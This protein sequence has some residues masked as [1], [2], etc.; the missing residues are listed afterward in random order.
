MVSDMNE[1]RLRLLESV[2][3][4]TPDAVMIT[5]SEPI[6]EPGP[7]IIYVNKAFTK[8]TGYS[9]H[10][11]LGRSPRFLQSKKTNRETLDRL[12]QALISRESFSAELINQKKDQ[13]EFWVSITIAPVKDDAGNCTH[14]VS[15]QRDITEQKKADSMLPQMAILTFDESN[16]SG[17]L[18]NFPNDITDKKIALEALQ[19]SEA[20]FRRVIETNLI[21]V[22]IGKLNGPISFSNDAFLDIIGYKREDL[23][24]GTIRWDSITPAEYMAIEKDVTVSVETNGSCKPFKKEYVRKDGLR[25]PA[26]VSLAKLDDK[27]DDCV[28]CVVDL[29]ELKRVEEQL[30]QSEI[31]Y[32]NALTSARIGTWS[33]DLH[34]DVI[35]WSPQTESLFGFD[36]GQF[37]GTVDEF[38]SC[39]HPDDKDEFNR[40]LK[41]AMES[42]ERFNYEF[43]VLWKDGSHHWLVATGEC[44][45]SEF[46]LPLQITGTVAEITLRK[47][48]EEALQ[49]LTRQLIQAQE[50]ERIRLARA[51]HDELGQALTAIKINLQTVKLPDE[52]MGSI[53]KMV[54]DSIQQIRDLSFD[55]RP[56]LLDDLGLVS[57]LRWYLER[58]GKKSGF[59]PYFISNIQRIRLPFDIET[60]CYRIVQEALTNI[61]R[62]SQAQNVYI[63]LISVSAKLEVFIKDDGVGFDMEKLKSGNAVNLGIAGMFERTQLVG[64]KIEIESSIG[65]GTEIRINFNLFPSKQEVTK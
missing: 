61:Q 42:R 40:V 29:T 23:E 1:E 28:G 33:W 50:N 39:I 37:R 32:Q 44:I 34:N 52:K 43:R 48:A 6:D 5:E 36:P 46:S 3:T 14:F 59:T 7:R 31:R 16:Q 64:G 17:G 8:M 56:S 54:D 38:Q 20:R 2:I 47:Q 25:V 26:L 18:Y 58:Q 53:L 15:I 21:G 9:E 11:V 12:R 41:R 49:S 35:Y 55:L 63:E 57:A 22:A 24:A 45:Y 27:G 51:L 30:I 19:K 62:H 65:Q 4:N 60:A 13:S 10:E